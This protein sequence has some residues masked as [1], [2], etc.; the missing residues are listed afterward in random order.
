MALV[1]LSPNVLVLP[2]LNPANNLKE[3]IRDS[4]GK[5]V[6]YGTAGIGSTPHLTADHLLRV[7]AGLDAVHVP[8]QGGAPAITAALGNHVT[9]TS[10]ALPPA[11]ADVKGGTLKGPAVT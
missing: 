6:S 9:L 11:V 1:A 7:L 4:K 2:P 3:F 10:V 5:H 8:Y